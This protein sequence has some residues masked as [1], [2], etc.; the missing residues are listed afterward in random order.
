MRLFINKYNNCR[1][2]FHF[3]YCL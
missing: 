1:V 3:V 2:V